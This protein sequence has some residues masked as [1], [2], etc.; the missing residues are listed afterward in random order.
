MHVA[1]AKL[2][3]DLRPGSPL[4]ASGTAQAVP[5]Q[6][7]CIQKSEVAAEAVPFQDIEFLDRLYDQTP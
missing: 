6:S 2:S 5:F 4:R 1:K 7:K 3:L